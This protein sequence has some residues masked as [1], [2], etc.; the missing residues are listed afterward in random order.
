MNSL[1]II[2]NIFLV[3]A[4]AAAGLINGQPKAAFLQETYIAPALP[5]FVPANSQTRFD[6]AFKLIPIVELAKNHPARSKALDTVLIFSR[7]I[8]ALPVNVSTDRRSIAYLFIDMARA[9]R[10]WYRT[11]ERIPAHYNARTCAGHCI[12]AYNLRPLRDNSEAAFFETF[13]EQVRFEMLQDYDLYLHEGYV[14]L[15]S[16]FPE[17]ENHIKQ[18]SI[19]R[20]QFS[21]Y[22]NNTLEL[23]YKKQD[24]ILNKVIKLHDQIIKKENLARQKYEASRIAYAEQMRSSNA[25]QQELTERLQE[26][27]NTIEQN[28]QA[29][30]YLKEQ[31]ADLA[32]FL[33]GNDAVTKKV[34][35]PVN[36]KSI[37]LLNDQNVPA[38]LFTTCTGNRIQI[39]L[40]QD[41]IE[42]LN[43]ATR[44]EHREVREMI[45]HGVIV[46]EELNRNGHIGKAYAVSDFCHALLDFSKGFVKGSWSSVSNLAHAIRHP[47]ETTYSIA[48]SIK[49]LYQTIQ[50]IDR[51]YNELTNDVK[52]ICIEYAINHKMAQKKLETFIQKNSKRAQKVAD[53]LEKQKNA[54]ASLSSEEWGEVTGRVVTDLYLCNRLGGFTTRATRHFQKTFTKAASKTK[55]IIKYNPG[56][57]INQST[58][59]ILKNGYYEVNGFK[60][61]EYYYNKLWANGRPAPSLFAKNIL[62]NAVTVI[63]DRA[64]EGFLRYTTKDWEMV[65]NPITKEVWHLQ[66]ISKG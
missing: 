37:R 5:L 28:Q 30:D 65:Y 58:E 19:N 23:G 15:I 9:L 27:N 49:D 57:I 18:L 34:D 3:F 62:E 29:P 52:N 13:N 17:Y 10:A 11:P 46:G 33:S 42:L 7:E 56:S 14:D 38:E 6:P 1:T 41:F 22:L 63:P 26:L 36:E 8:N 45:T 55:D 64:K 16:C 50:R 48:S 47:V 43:Q 40:H 21:T 35:F 2:K 20:A 24:A 61:S 39:K 51:L 4:V 53:I 66:P 12:A 60:F 54:L 25:V 31:A 59:A 44:I 32:S